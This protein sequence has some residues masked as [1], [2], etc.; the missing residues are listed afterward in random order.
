M[1]ISEPQITDRDLDIFTDF[2]THVLLNSDHLAAIHGNSDGHRRRLRRRIQKLREAGYIKDLKTPIDRP[3]EFVL[4]QRG[5]NALSDAR[6]FAPKRMSTP[7]STRQ[8]RHHDLALSD[9]TVAVDL[10]VRSLESARLID[11]LELIHRSP[12]L[13]VRS[14]RGWPVSFRHEENT[15]EHW[16]KPDRFL[17]IEFADRPTNQNVRYF[18]IEIDRGTMPLQAS[19]LHKASI[20]RKLLAYQATHVDA[21]L[22]EHFVI[23]HAYTLFIAPGR[24]RRDNMVKLAQEVVRHDRAAEAMLF[25]VQ[26]PAPSVGQYADLSA[27]QWINGR[28]EGVELPL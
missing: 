13:D 1:A 8:F 16:V 17:G 15:L 2:Y 19:S 9:F 10:L 26:P 12:R 27:L 5:M 3:K 7:R 21:V 24:R 4:A 25:A 11:E 28:G 18:A 22:Q 20:L 14:H 23:P 6:S